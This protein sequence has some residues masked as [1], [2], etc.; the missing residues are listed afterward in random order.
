MEDTKNHETQTRPQPS[1]LHML[2]K[3]R[4]V[5]AGEAEHP[6]PYVFP[7]KNRDAALVEPRNDAAKVTRAF[8]VTPRT[9]NE[10][11]IPCRKFVV[12]CPTRAASEQ[13]K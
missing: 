1:Y 7:G 4:K 10:G 8:G 9:W 2:L 11:A 12:T 13:V 3:D 5:L 6:S